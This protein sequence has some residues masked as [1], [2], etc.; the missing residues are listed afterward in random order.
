MSALL[1]DFIF[2]WKRTFILIIEERPWWITILSWEC[3]QVFQLYFSCK[4]KG[5]TQKKAACGS[6]VGWLLCV[7]LFL[8]LLWLSTHLVASGGCEQPTQSWANSLSL[9]TEPV[10]GHCC[11]ECTDK[12]MQEISIVVAYDSHVFSQRHDEDFLASLVAIS[13]PKYVVGVQIVKYCWFQFLF[14]VGSCFSLWAA[15]FSLHWLDNI[16]Q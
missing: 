9:D 10:A 6:W 5:N 16:S 11:R 12:M 14:S 8:F 3:G 7:F 2:S 15:T 1:L 4:D 13:K